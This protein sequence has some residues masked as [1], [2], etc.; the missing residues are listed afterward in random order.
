VRRAKVFEWWCVWFLVSVVLFV[1]L[2]V[3][4]GV[5]WGPALGV[6]VLQSLASFRLAGAVVTTWQANEV[7]RRVAEREASN[8][9]KE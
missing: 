1:G 9:A 4:G 7:S 2:Q 3:V 6:I 8:A 5:H